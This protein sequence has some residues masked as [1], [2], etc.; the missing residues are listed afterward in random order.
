MPLTVIG[1]LRTSPAVKPALMAIDAALI[2]V[3][4]RSVRLS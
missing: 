3:L 2:W 1:R 4:S